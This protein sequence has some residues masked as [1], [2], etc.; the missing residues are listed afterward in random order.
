MGYCLA[1]LLQGRGTSRA[2]WGAVDAARQSD[3]SF[4]V[5]ER[6]HPVNEDARRSV[7]TYAPGVAD[8]LHLLVG[9]GDVGPLCY[10]DG[11]TLVSRFPVR[12]A[13]EVLQGNLHEMTVDLEAHY[14]VKR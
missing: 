14:K 11:E 5:R 6:V 7:K 3:A 12:T 4:C 10:E 1:Q 13:V 9:H 8:R 2:L